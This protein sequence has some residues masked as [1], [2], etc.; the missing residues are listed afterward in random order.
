MAER[1]RQ[2]LAGSGGHVV[3]TIPVVYRD[4]NPSGETRHTMLSNEGSPLLIGIHI[5]CSQ[6]YCHLN[7]SSRRRA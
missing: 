4:S 5:W 3:I 2:D 7:I 1:P 6:R